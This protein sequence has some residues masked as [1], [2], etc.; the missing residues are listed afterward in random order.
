MSESKITMDQDEI[1]ALMK[2]GIERGLREVRRNYRSRR[3][4]EEDPSPSRMAVVSNKILKALRK[5]YNDNRATFKSPQQARALQLIVEGKT[6]VLAIL[7]T[8]GG[9]SLLFFLPTLLEP[10]MTTVV[11]V[12]LIAVMQDLR[13]RCVKAKISCANWD[14]HSRYGERCNLLFVAVEHAVQPAFR[15]HL[16]VMY[17]MRILKRIVM[18][19]VHV[20]L[21]H[22]DFRP[23][24][25]KLI[26]TLRTV[27]V[28]VALLTATM[29]PGMEWEL[30]IALA[31][32]IWEVVRA[33]TMR[34]EI[35]YEVVEV[36]EEEDTL[37]VEIAFRIKAEMRKWSRN[38]RGELNGN[39][40]GIVYCLQKKWAEDL[41]KFL[42]AELGEDICDVYHADLSTEVRAAVY[43][44]WQEGTI[45][46]LVATSALGLGIDY[47]HVR[48]VIHQGQSRSLMDFSQES[49]RGGRDGEEAR[50]VIFTS[51]E[52]RAKCAWMEKK[53]HEWAGHLT[54]GFKAMGEWVAG[55]M[56]NG[57]KQCRRVGLGS[58]MDGIGTNCLSMRDCVLCDICEEAMDK[59]TEIESE[60]EGESGVWSEIEIEND[61]CS[62]NGHETDGDEMDIDGGEMWSQSTIDGLQENLI[63][64]NTET[65]WQVHTAIKIREMMSVFHKRCVLCWVREIS[66]KHILKDCRVMP[67][68]CLRCQNEDHSL[69][70]CVDVMYKGGSC[71][72]KCGL[73]QM[74]GENYIHGDMRIGACEEGWRDKMF[75]LCYY[76]WRKSGWRE[77]LES[78]FRREWT[79]EGFREWICMIDRGITNGVRIMLWIWDEIE[80]K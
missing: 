25:E 28:Q 19:E 3:L 46:I 43:R 1:A 32:V 70:E 52:M 80:N 48:F 79:E 33:E 41:C 8:G 77:R 11:I 58:H 64:G 18:D 29:P 53:E 72:W 9:K 20:A 73:P 23:D 63:T 39:E 68:K 78:H 2:S 71:C 24:M 40:R 15:D 55:K 14:P 31:C 65:Q 21:T 7:P 22:R 50:S 35:G 13:D 59:I 27:P 6:D 26:L 61:D 17:G 56:M 37:D 45:K 36:D 42:N 74:L 66:A 34:P 60:G 75:P 38:E 4:K 47:S 76:L 12:P 10:D 49:G 44:E 62:E 51:K 54:G 16:Q 67:G 30:R 69:K 57:V 5:F